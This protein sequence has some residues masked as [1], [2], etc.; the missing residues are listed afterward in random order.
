MKG[1]ELKKLREGMNLTQAELAEKI[2]VRSNTIARYERGE[3]KI[4]EPVA[5]LVKILAEKD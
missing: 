5:R 1:S 3:L 4:P 2:G